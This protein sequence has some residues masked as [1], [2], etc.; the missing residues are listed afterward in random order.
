MNPRKI[1]GGAIVAL[2]AV[3]IAYNW[4][5]ANVRFFAISVQMPLGLLVLTSAALGSIATMLFQ[6]VAHKRK[7]R[8]A[9]AK[10]IE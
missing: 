3:F 7:S 2:L 10:Q 4:T 8:S 9:P 5:G 1:V 6:F